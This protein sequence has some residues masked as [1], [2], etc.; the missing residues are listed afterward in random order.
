MILFNN[1]ASGD[2]GDDSVI[3]SFH[4]SDGTP[5]ASGALLLG[6]SAISVRI[7]K[8]FPLIGTSAVSN[9][10]FGKFAKVSSWSLLHVG[11]QFQASE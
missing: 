8:I 9:S 2:V 11:T 4:T 3:T 1:F 7:N 10:V 5:S 6:V